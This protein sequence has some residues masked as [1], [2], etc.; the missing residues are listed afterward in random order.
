MVMT[1]AAMM[2]EAAAAVAA[3]AIATVAIVVMRIRVA[4][5][6]N[7]I[8][9]TGGEEEDEEV[10]ELANTCTKVPRFAKQ[11][12]VSSTCLA[13]EVQAMANPWMVTAAATVVVLVAQGLELSC[14]SRQPLLQ[15]QNISL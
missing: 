7:T 4:A 1:L 3:V 15:K 13:V 11:E 14:F 10:K 12:L 6:I 8:I 2:I 9:T 5:Q